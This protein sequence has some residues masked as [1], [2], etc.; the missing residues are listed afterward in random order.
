[1]SSEQP[2]RELL[3][4]FKTETDKNQ[5]ILDNVL[6]MLSRRVYLTKEGINKPLYD[7]ESKSYKEAEDN[8]YVIKTDDGEKYALRI[9][10]QKLGI[11]G[12]QSPIMNFIEEFP[13][14]HKILIAN[15]YSNKYL[16]FEAETNALLFKEEKKEIQLFKEEDFLEDILT[17]LEQPKFQLLT[18]NEMKDVKKAYNASNYTLTKVLK[19]DPVVRYL[20][21][22][23]GDIY[24]IIRPS[25]TAMYSIAYRI[26]A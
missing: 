12:R 4:I 7:L 3:Q 5:I 16:D 13:L 26:V 19:N 25:P 17:K 23:K 14:Y 8:T 22:K 18:P 21:I 10:Y 24:R 11:T 6:R 2:K 9:I 1:M 15:D 20:A